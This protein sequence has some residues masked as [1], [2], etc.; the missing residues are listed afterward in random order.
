MEVKVIKVF[1]VSSPFFA[2]AVGPLK[3]DTVMS[4]FNSFSVFFFL[5]FSSL[6]VSI[7]FSFYVELV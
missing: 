2:D 1:Y 4:L 6:V 7:L 5:I 3:R